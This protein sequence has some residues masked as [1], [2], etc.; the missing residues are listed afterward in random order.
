MNRP[1]RV[2]W[3]G[4]WRREYSRNRILI[5]GLR[6]AGVEV[7]E[8]HAPLW[9]EVEDRVRLASG[10]WCHPRFAL[11]LF[12]AWFRLLSGLRRTGPWDALV[13]GYP[14]LFDVPL[15]RL[16]ARHRRRKVVLDAFMSPW[17]IA[18]ER[19]L[20]ARAPF[21]GRLLHAL[22]RAAL[23]VP[24]LILQ[25]TP[26]YAAWTRREFGVPP[27]RVRLVPT[28][29]D[30]TLF[31]PQPRLPPTDGTF[32]VVYVGTF[33][34]NHGVG[35]M[36]EA[37]A[38]LQGVPEIRFRFVGDGP[39]RA[40]AERQARTL[41][42]TRVQF[43]PP[44]PPERVPACLAEA[45]LALGAFG[46]TPQSLMTIQNKI[47]EALAMARPVV[48]GDSPAV[49]TLF[50]HG[51]HLWLCPRQDAEALAEAIRFLSRHPSLG[52]T[53]AEEGYARF[54]E[55]GSVE[56][57]GRTLRAHLEEAVGR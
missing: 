40:E 28:G 18:W 4:T 37:A 3:F 38:R 16:A 46:T 54:R 27:E 56:A 22:E 45:D 30:T 43:D 12:L 20:V 51:R 36:I 5:A 52:R 11:R 6:S 32:R 25:D 44:L 55:V 57:I 14:G 48:T 17:L 23:A 2:C 9:G 19:G 10:G 1:L 35:T 31:K 8:C 21:T 34:P 47:Y 42:L 26:Q 33:I 49:R 53:L 29:A 13:L 50:E 39:E 7:V 41:G 15:A 24:D